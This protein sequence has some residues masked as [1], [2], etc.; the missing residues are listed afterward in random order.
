MGNI[1]KTVKKVF[2]TPV[3]L[4]GDDKNK[5]RGLQDFV[6]MDDKEEEKLLKKDSIGKIYWYDRFFSTPVYF[7]TWCIDIISLLLEGA[8][9]IDISLKRKPRK[10][11]TALNPLLVLFSSLLYFLVIITLGCLFF[12]GVAII[13]GW[14]VTHLLGDF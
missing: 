7:L 6:E 1:R 2:T 14:I 13:F 3:Y 5:I 10:L 4:F 12:G 8:N 11:K 9:G